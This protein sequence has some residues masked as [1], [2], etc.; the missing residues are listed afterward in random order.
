MPKYC[1]RQRFLLRGLRARR[2]E[3]VKG[4]EGEWRY[5]TDKTFIYEE[6]LL[7]ITDSESL[8]PITDLTDVKVIA[9]VFVDILQSTLH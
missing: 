4:D 5:K 2:D 8:F 9:Q 3:D 1:I 6:R 7:R